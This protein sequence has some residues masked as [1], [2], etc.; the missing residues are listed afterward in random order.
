MEVGEHLLVT[1]SSEGVLM[2][3]NK[4]NMGAF[5]R[6]TPHGDTTVLVLKVATLYTQI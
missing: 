3:R 5:Y 1:G 4:E 6:D 2:V